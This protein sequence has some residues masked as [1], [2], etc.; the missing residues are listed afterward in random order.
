MLDC[1]SD[2][3]GH[4][5]AGAVTARALMQEIVGDPFSFFKIIAADNEAIRKLID[6]TQAFQDEIDVQ[7]PDWA[8]IVQDFGKGRY[9]CNCGKVFKTVADLEAHGG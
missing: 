9:R 2:I 3:L 7:I 5:A 4:H 8:K 1:K 6:S